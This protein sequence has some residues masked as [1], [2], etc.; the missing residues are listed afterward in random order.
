MNASRVR[1]ILALAAFVLA[2]AAAIVGTPNRPV[3]AKE[4]DQISPLELA[5][6]IKAGKPGLHIVDVRTAPEFDRYHIP[7][8]RSMP[9][10]AL[11][12]ARFDPN[13]TI[14][15]YGERGGHAAQA[16]SVLRESG[17]PHVLSLRGGIEDWLEDVMHPA[18]PT[19]VT[20]YFGGFT[21]K[22]G[23][24]PLTVDALRRHG[25]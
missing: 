13:A 25:C 1:P 21:R 11:A 22:P 15:L 7:T 24:A 20:R 5:E 10:E 14:V 3:R 9:L 18:V 16:W 4:S 6:W 23:D 17:Y 19:G 2:G 8:A 12:A